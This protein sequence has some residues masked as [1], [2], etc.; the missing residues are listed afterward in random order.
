M[1]FNLK[2]KKILSL[3]GCLFSIML[4]IS[5]CFFPFPY[6]R[7]LIEQMKDSNQSLANN[8]IPFKTIY[9][10]ITEAF[11]Y[12]LFGNIAYQIFGNILLFAPL[13]FSINFYLKNNKKLLKSFICVVFI[14]ISIE[15][16]QG[17]LNHLLGVNY[18][19]V[20]IDD[21]IL[22]TIGGI[23]GYIAAS[24]IQDLYIKNRNQKI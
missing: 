22:N 13:G 18:R 15:A 23:L 2:D 24:Y 9:T 6:Q 5:I 20:D 21:L 10:I 16:L 1:N 11:K 4:I 17:Y 8:F 19:S 12:K 3:F 7:A 14:S